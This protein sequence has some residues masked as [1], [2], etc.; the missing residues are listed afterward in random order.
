MGPH[1]LTAFLLALA[2]GPPPLEHVFELKGHAGWVRQAAFAP[3]NR[4]AVS[5]GDDGIVRVW[6]VRSGKEAMALAG[7]VG[8]VW[9]A[10][11]SPDGRRIASAGKD[12]TIRLW[13]AKAGRLLRTMRG[14]ADDVWCVAFSPDGKLLASGGVDADVRLWDVGT[15]KCLRKQ[16]GHGG[17][18]RSV[19]F[20]P[21]G[22]EVAS[23]GFDRTVRTWDVRTGQPRL[24]LM[25]RPAG[26]VWGVAYSPDGTS[27]LAST[28]KGAFHVFD[29][30]TDGAAC[31]SR[32]CRT[33]CWPPRSAP[34]A[35]GS[36]AGWGRKCG[37]GT[38]APGRR[39]HPVRP[40]ATS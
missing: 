38:P 16:A 31:M 18:V 12:G 33:T 26:L 17:A 19:A 6:D 30:R 23:G 11:F 4:L 22:K 1:A 20:S 25:G 24:I 5:A 36:S 9:Q 40:T 8:G 34:T 13:D 27:L 37:C 2:A 15:G 7:H 35:G 14:H 3:G 10:V 28:G 32:A 39:W 29:L 21:R